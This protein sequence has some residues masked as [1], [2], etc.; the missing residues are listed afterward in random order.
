MS[1]FLERRKRRVPHSGTPASHAPDQPAKPD[2]AGSD[3]FAG[4]PQATTAWIGALGI[5]AGLA[6]AGFIG[7][8]SLQ[9]FLGIELGNWTAL[10]LSIFAGRWAI[11]TLTIVLQGT[12]AHPFLWGGPILLYL[13]P[14]LLSFT[15]P[16]D[17]RRGQ[18]AARLSIVFAALGLCYAL[19]WCEVPTLSLKNWL[20]SE[21]GDQFVT[22]LPNKAATRVDDIRTTLLVSKMDG[23]VQ[24]PDPL[25]PLSVKSL[26]VCGLVGDRIP[27]NLRQHLKGPS[28]IHAAKET[29]EGIYAACVIICL[30]SLV[31]LY[32]HQVVEKPTLL[33]DGFRLLRISASYVLLPLVAALIPYMYGKLIYPS[34]FPSV[35]VTLKGDDAKDSEKSEK[36][37]AG[38]PKGTNA[39]EQKGKPAAQP[40]AKPIDGDDA[41]A[42]NSTSRMLVVDETDKD[43]SLLD[44]QKNAPY[45]IE[46]RDRSEITYIVRYGKEDVLNTILRKGKWLPGMPV[47]CTFPQGVQ[48]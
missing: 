40:A 1:S 9:Q 19:V 12:L 20:T 13:A 47:N 45:E 28:P 7:K 5:T 39:A 37:S 15:F 16:L 48:P 6:A 2:G 18:I 10:D 46:I 44:T 43:L 25:L 8:L 24:V 23:V 4:L 31:A 32:L 14:T 11:D 42:S 35:T 21:I 22:P 30:T 3:G 27:D 29:L 34:T 36:D 38:Q 41:P 17:D 26:T 33:D